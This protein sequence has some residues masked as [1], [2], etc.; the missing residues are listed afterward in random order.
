MISATIASSKSL[1]LAGAEKLCTAVTSESAQTATLDT[2]VIDAEEKLLIQLGYVLIN[3]T[4]MQE[5]VD[6]VTL[7]CVNFVLGGKRF[8]SPRDI[9][10]YGVQKVTCVSLLWQINEDIIVAINVSTQ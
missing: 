4:I 5:D 9:A 3:V 2:R 6:Y 8:V 1:Q 7:I 10:K